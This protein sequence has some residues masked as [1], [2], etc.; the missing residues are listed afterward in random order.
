MSPPETKEPFTDWNP[1][2][3]LPPGCGCDLLANIAIRAGSILRGVPLERLKYLAKE[4]ENM[5]KA[6]ENKEFRIGQ[7]GQEFTFTPW[8][9]PG[10]TEVQAIVHE[11]Q[12]WNPAPPFGKAKEFEYL[13][14]Y[15]LL[16]LEDAIRPHYTGRHEQI[17]LDYWFDYPQPLAAIHAMESVCLAESLRELEA[18]YSQASVD[19][20]AKLAGGGAW[21]AELAAKRVR[22]R[23]QETV[24]DLTTEKTKWREKASKGGTTRQALHR[25]PK[26]QVLAEYAR[27]KSK[28]ESLAKAA[29]R[30]T[31]WLEAKSVKNE[32]IGESYASATVYRWLRKAREEGKI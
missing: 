16:R 31:N 5:V 22:E 3:G 15:S 4:A 25:P 23:I 2:Q 19:G 32:G 17:E 10:R 9:R 27:T 24:R 1:R 18:V 14:A 13:A 11:V 20:L 29:D 26:Q 28:G 6:H 7:K 12:N 30:L 8:P 21:A